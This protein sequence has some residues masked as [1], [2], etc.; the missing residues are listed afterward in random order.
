MLKTLLL[1]GA[2][3]A[4]GRPAFAQDAF[5]AVRCG[6]D[7]PSALKGKAMPGGRVVR[8]EARHR[9]IGLKDEGAEEVSETLIY[10]A[11]SM[12]GNEFAMLEDRRGI[13][14]DATLFPAHSRR[15]PA[16]LGPCQLGGQQTP[17]M[18]LGILDNTASNGDPQHYAPQDSTMLR[19][20]RAWGIDQHLSRFVAVPAKDL[21]C[22]RGNIF[23]VDGGP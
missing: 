6:A 17:G 11:W 13:I 12:C 4:L 20:I 22:P 19:A 10:Q 3:L 18:I 8:I 14:R 1:T 9:D 15:H 16:F 2:L 7:I 23:T 21:R 5:S